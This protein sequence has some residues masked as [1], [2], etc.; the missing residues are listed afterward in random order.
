MTI[1][2]PIVPGIPA[3]NSNPVS[4]FSLAKEAIA[5]FNAPASALILV[6]LSAETSVKFFKETTVPSY[7]SSETRR[8]LPFPSTKYSAPSALKHSMTFKSCA[9]S[10]GLINKLAGPPVLNVVCLLMFSFN[11]IFSSETISLSLLIRSL[12]KKNLLN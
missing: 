8:L 5:E 2:P 1:A 10:F 3:A 6:S 4:S 11:M 7:P 9:V 12:F